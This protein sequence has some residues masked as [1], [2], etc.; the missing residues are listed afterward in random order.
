M[1][2]LNRRLRRLE[3]GG[4]VSGPP[5]SLGEFLRLDPSSHLLERPDWKRFQRNLQRL[6]DDDGG[7]NIVDPASLG[8]TG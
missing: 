7:P 5:P 3:L 1:S 4:R 6:I 8:P 2:D